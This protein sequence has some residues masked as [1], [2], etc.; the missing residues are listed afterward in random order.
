VIFL[1]ISL[2]TAA[3]IRLFEAWV[4]RKLGMV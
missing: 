3:G 2:P 4:R 1:L